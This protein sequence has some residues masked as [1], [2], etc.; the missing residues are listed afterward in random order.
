MS[1]FEWS[2]G[3]I[4]VP[5]RMAEDEARWLGGMVKELLGEYR[6]EQPPDRRTLSFGDIEQIWVEEV[7]SHLK[8]FA[9]MKEILDGQTEGP[10]PQSQWR[11]II[12]VGGLVT[13]I[14]SDSPHSCMRSAYA[15]TIP[16]GIALAEPAAYLRSV[17]VASTA[18]PGPD[19][20]VGA[21][22][23]RAGASGCV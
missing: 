10:P 9:S 21:V 18:G 7:Q 6:R 11:L 19:S 17:T 1:N 3:R 15:Q 13:R 2:V 8:E 22:D 20:L 14:P 16:L 5:K 12:S 4:V 23:G